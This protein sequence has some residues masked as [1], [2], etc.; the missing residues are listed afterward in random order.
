MITL[1]ATSIDHVNMAVN[2][3]DES[4]AFYSELFGFEVRKEQPEPDSKR[5]RLERV[6]IRRRCSS[7]RTAGPAITFDARKENTV[8]EGARKRGEAL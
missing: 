1:N 3:L 7:S 6:D 4:V 5:Q 8:D 2:N